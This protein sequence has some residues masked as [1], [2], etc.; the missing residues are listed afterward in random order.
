MKQKVSRYFF[1]ALLGGLLSLGTVDAVAQC[2]M[3]KANVE[4][5]A[6]SKLSKVGNGLNSGIVYLMAIPY[7]LAATV[8]FLWYKN[9]RRA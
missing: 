9:S 5:N 4:S 7:V 3:C 2:A 1:L 6:Q 8:G